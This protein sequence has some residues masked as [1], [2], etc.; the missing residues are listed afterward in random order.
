MQIFPIRKFPKYCT[1]FGTFTAVKD[2][3]MEQT[4][5]NGLHDFIISFIMGS[6]MVLSAVFISVWFLLYYL[7]KHI[8]ENIK[9]IFQFYTR[10]LP[11]ELELKIVVHEKLCEK[12]SKGGDPN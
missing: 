11:E 9:F 8:L 4:M 5:D 2:R 6:M 10:T 12:Q 7:L 1:P 3:I